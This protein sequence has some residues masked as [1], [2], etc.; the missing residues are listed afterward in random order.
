MT[1]Q[2]NLENIKTKEGKTPRIIPKQCRLLMRSFEE[3]HD[4]VRPPI[5]VKKYVVSPVGQNL[6][7]LSLTEEEQEVIKQSIRVTPENVVEV[8]TNNQL[9][10][11]RSKSCRTLKENEEADKMIEKGELPPIDLPHPKRKDMKT[12]RFLTDKLFNKNIK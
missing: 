10:N 12:T 2:Y 7:N 5:P 3:L 8:N 11:Q 1:T 4:S 6:I 9:I